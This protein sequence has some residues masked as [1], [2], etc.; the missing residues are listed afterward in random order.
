MVRGQPI[1][2]PALLDGSG[3]RI[4]LQMPH[5]KARTVVGL[6]SSAGTGCSSS[7]NRFT[8]PIVPSVSAL[9]LLRTFPA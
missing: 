3:G 8:P 4:E 2:D 6:Y 9:R 7:W 1:L 5:S